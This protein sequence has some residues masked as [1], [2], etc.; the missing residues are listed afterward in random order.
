MNHAT[1][2]RG[3]WKR[4]HLLPKG[5]SGVFWF[6]FLISLAVYTFTL[7]PSITLDEAGQRVVAAD[8]L[9][10]P[11]STGYPLWT[12]LAW[13]FQW[14]LGFVT[15]RGHPNPAWPVAFMSAVFGALSSGVLAVLI[16]RTSIRFAG[17]LLS[18]PRGPSYSTTH[19]YSPAEKPSGSWTSRRRARVVTGLMGRRTGSALRMS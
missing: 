11:L 10:V 6:C 4:P 2:I 18:R 19:S 3:N 17:S 14:V 15:Y 7:P 9:G 12:A 5:E 1:P 13:F 8:Y 16:R